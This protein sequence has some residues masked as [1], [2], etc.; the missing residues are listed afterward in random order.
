MTKMLSHD[1]ILLRRVRRFGAAMGVL[2]LA[3]GCA[4]TPAD[5]DVAEPERAV[6]PAALP[7]VPLTAELLY[8]ILLGEIAGQR[9]Y[10]D[11]AVEAL[12]RAALSSKDPRLLARAGRRAARAGDHDKALE[13]AQLWAQVQP[14]HPAPAQL[15]GHALLAMGRTEEAYEQFADLI[16]HSEPEV[17]GAYRRIADLLARSGNTDGLLA[18]MDR[19]IALHPE[20][21]EAYYSK[22]FLADRLKQ[23]TV[24]GASIDQALM[25]R[26]DWEDAALGKFGHLA[27]SSSPEAAETFADEYL[28]DHPDAPRLRT[29]YARFLVDRENPR[30]ALIHFKYLADHDGENADAAFAVGLLSIQIDELRQA[31]DYLLRNLALQEDNDQ[32]RLYLGQVALELKDYEGAETWYREVRQSEYA[33]EA[34][35]LLATVFAKRGNLDGAIAHLQT[36][37]PVDDEQKLQLYLGQER[38]YRETK[39]LDDAKV[40][41]DSAL[42]ELPDHPELLYARGLVAAQLNMLE[43]HESDLRKLIARDPENAHAY[44]ALG[45]TLADQTSRYDE[46]LDLVGKALELKPGDPFIMDSMGWVQYR[47]GNIESAIDYLERALHSRPDAEIA[48][49]LGEV[50]WVTGNQ[51]RAKSIWKEALKKSPDN[52]LLLGTIRKLQQ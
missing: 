32:T 28:R 29:R 44:N 37:E 47:L 51:R 36:I 14:D 39:R 9:G 18:L 15:S 24:I 4:S 26:P 10:G 13:I 42:V 34:Q 11:V 25:L 40:V 48:A 17:G 16:R 38:V 5:L 31:R 22:A 30:D 52:D 3:V 45:Y 19:L 21:A 23:V 49:H 1:K 8:D 35:M 7:D 6:P 27:D 41:L 43:L 20:S 2:W 50:L 46:A 33:F 12:S